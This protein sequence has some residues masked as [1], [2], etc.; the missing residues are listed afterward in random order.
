M[1]Q[2]KITILIINNDSSETEDLKSRL[3]QEMRVPW[4]MAHCV[5][6]K[7]AESRINKADVVILKPEMEGLI[8]PREAYGDIEHMVFETPI[9]VLTDDDEDKD[10][11]S[12]Y[13]M[14]K[15][16]ADILIRGQFS[17]LV[18]AI[19][20]ALIRQKITTRDR[21]VADKVLKDSKDAGDK[22]YKDSCDQREIDQKETRNTLSLFMGGYSASDHGSAD[23]KTSE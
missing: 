22:K 8:T 15:G 9:I 14:E 3:A 7:E 19:E 12:T 1:N 16:A 18:D 23:K 5:S 6:V 13:V 2:E 20:F 4:D 11:L 21:R 10:G 17:R